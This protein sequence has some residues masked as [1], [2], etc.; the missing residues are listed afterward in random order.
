MIQ[1]TGK[2]TWKIPVRAQECTVKIRGKSCMRGAPFAVKLCRA[3]D[4]GTAANL[5]GSCLGKNQLTIN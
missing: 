4:N 5:I 1:C 2:Y 3:D